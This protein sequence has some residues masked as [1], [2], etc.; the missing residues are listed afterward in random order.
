VAAWRNTSLPPW[1]KAVG[2]GGAQAGFPAFCFFSTNAA[3]LPGVSRQILR[4]DKSAR[5]AHHISVRLLLARLTDHLAVGNLQPFN[6]FFEVNK[7]TMQG[8]IK[9][10]MLSAEVVAN[11]VAE[12]G[13]Q[14]TSDYTGKQLT[15]ICILKGASIFAS[16]LFRRIEL[17]ATIDFMAISSYGNRTQSSGVVR[18][19][20]DLDVSIEG[21]DVLIVEDIVDS[22]LTLSYLVDNLRSRHPASLR[23]CVLLDKPERR[24]VS[25]SVDYTGFKIPDQFVVGYG[26]DYAEKYR[27]VPYIGV[28]KPEVYS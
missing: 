4:H 22:G 3:G 7:L 2:G 25:I 21:K 8:D 13:K 9:E 15:M 26:L 17:P 16:D 10:I 23:T 14:I 24:E 1:G 18:I 12:L 28:L 11:R 19:S 20:K 27:N 6:K 5:T